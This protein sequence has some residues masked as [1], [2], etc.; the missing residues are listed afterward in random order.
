VAAGTATS[1][2]ASVVG[3]PSNPAISVPSGEVIFFDSVDGGLERRLGSGFLTTGNGGKLI[4]TLPVVL[5]KGH[6]VIHA[7]YLGTYDWNAADSNAIQII[8]E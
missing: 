2:T 8:V 1:V 6:N 3:V 7:R 4:F 5:P